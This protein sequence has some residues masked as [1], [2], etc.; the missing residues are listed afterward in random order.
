MRAIVG[1]SP[2]R[3]IGYDTSGD[4]FPVPRIGAVYGR[5]ASR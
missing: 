4:A 2:Q 3:W 1:E 5:S